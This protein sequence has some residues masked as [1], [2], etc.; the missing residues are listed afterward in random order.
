MSCSVLI[1]PK[2]VMAMQCVTGLRLSVSI[3]SIPLPLQEPVSGAS[4][5]ESLQKLSL[6]GSKLFFREDPLFFQCCQSLNLGDDIL[7]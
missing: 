3:T 7:L 2:S 1:I 5:L 4:R 6:C